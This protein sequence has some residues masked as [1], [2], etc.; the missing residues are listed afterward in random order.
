M[1]M[2][3]YRSI[4]LL[5]LILS[6]PGVLMVNPILAGPEDIL[7]S[8][9]RPFRA[10]SPRIPESGILFHEPIAK[11]M[12][13]SSERLVTGQDFRFENS[14]K[15]ALERFESSDD[16]TLQAAG[17]A[18]LVPYRDPTQ[19]FSRNVLITRDFG[20]F[21]VQ[22]EPVLAVNP[23]DPEHL[24]VGV[25]D[26][27]FPSVVSYVSIDGGKTWEGAYQTK[28]IAEDLGSSGDPISTFDRKGNVYMGSISA[29][30]E[31]INLAGIPLQ[32][33]VSSISIAKSTDGGKTWNNPVSSARSAVEVQF[34]R[35]DLGDATS[36]SMGSLR[37]GF[38]D[39]PWLMAGPNPDNPDE[40]ILYVAYTH[41]VTS[42]VFEF[43]LDGAFLY[44]RYPLLETTIEL[45]RSTDYGETW[46]DPVAISPTV[47]S[48]Y[49]AGG[50]DQADLEESDRVVQFP[51][52]FTHDD[53]TVYVAYLD[54]TDD[55][56]FKGIGEIYVAKST[57]GGKTFS[58]ER[59]ATFQEPYYRARNAPF[60]S[61][62]S[63]F[64][65]G[66]VGPDGSLSLIYGARPSDK[67]GD[68]GD[69][70]F[71][72]SDAQAK[73]WSLPKRINDDSSD[74]YQF[75]PAL[76]VAPDGIIHAFWGDFR[77]DDS[78]IRYH[79]YYTRSED[80]GNTWLDNSR[81][82]DY[83]TNPNRAFPGGVFIGDYNDI[84]ATADDV[85]MI[86][87]D[88]RL[89]EFGTVNQ[90]VAFARQT[91]MP[92]P[93]IFISPPSGPGGRD[94]TITGF[95]FQAD[96]EIFVMVSGVMISST[97]TNAD[98]NFAT[99]IFIPIAGEGA[100]DITVIEST[101]NLATASFYMNF[102][103]DDLSEFDQ[104]LN[105]LSDSI[106]I[107]NNEI[108]NSLEGFNIP[109]NDQS[110]I[111]SR[112][113]TTLENIDSNIDLLIDYSETS[114]TVMY[115]SLAVLLSVVVLAFVAYSKPQFKIPKLS[116]KD[117]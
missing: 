45:V 57:D 2:K 65:R 82:T 117:D 18:A 71:V 105:D 53:G 38:L 97:R 84:Y 5:F 19:K 64:P 48:T 76:S 90:K 107:S 95:N 7:W 101:G 20:T 55:G 36:T 59:A 56:P 67:P 6:G 46:S 4:I 91:L 3:K 41:F 73:S 44:F 85:Y 26:Y 12:S 14:K 96:Q 104:R 106:I 60:R 8:D 87:T 116:R 63:A 13:G 109:L 69:I 50:N 94:V 77:D 54:S 115:T 79:M 68:D 62:A 61:W 70:F 21:P 75:F 88:G 47:I 22:T 110:N 93:S 39:K 83:P 108:M 11:Y 40:D 35:N 89:G 66:D 27:N 10:I 32:E 102:G 80:G 98:G 23:N 58:R 37:F 113:Y 15:S 16:V 99:Q 33:V 100:H 92:T 17:A 103:F 74:S 81:V 86:W 49:S 72:R 78:D 111:D 1:N 24:V 30:A 31:E 43:A 51:H 9:V 28:Y 42:Y 112:L 25:I 34:Q 114:V 52:I 29:G